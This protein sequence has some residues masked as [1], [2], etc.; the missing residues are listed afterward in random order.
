MGFVSTKVVICP[1]LRRLLAGGLLTTLF[2]ISA[3]AQRAEPGRDLLVMTSTNDATHNQV[4]VF[5]LE[6]SPTPSLQ[7]DAILATGG[8]GGAGGNAGG[9]Q[10]AGQ[11]GA[12]VNYGSNTVSKLI[13]QGNV[14]A[15]SGTVNLA[16]GCIHPLS[17]ALNSSRLFVAGETCAEGH[18][19]P[20]G[21]VAGPT[22]KLPDT[23]AGQ[24]AAGQTWAA[25]TLKSGSVL[26]LP[27]TAGDLLAGNSTAVALPA[28]ANNTPL[29]A[30][31][32]GDLLG[33]NPAHSPD[34][35]ALVDAARHVYPVLGPQPA[36]P[37]NAPCWLAKGP[38]N[39]WYSGNSPGQAISIFFT[40]GQGGVFYKSVSLPGVPTDITLSPDRK[41]LAVIYTAADG[42]GGR[43]AVFSVDARGDLSPVATSSPV[44][45]VPAFNGVAISQ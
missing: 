45:G 27:L 5:R 26:Q 38:G 24:I 23:T 44:A 36:Y 21:A 8:A 30:A 37:T 12:V 25:V 9:L 16:S 39:A 18:T 1:A 43:I 11:F 14:V 33:F 22:V 34:S 31:F 15:V 29:G 6:T 3:L 10:F 40:D 32:W 20:N 41:W 35:L 7:L 2:A 19:W 4:I 17:V 28:N 42:S 13:R